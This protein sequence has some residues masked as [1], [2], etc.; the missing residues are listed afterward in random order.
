MNSKINLLRV[1]VL[2]AALGLMV[3]GLALAA[4]VDFSELP[5]T[6]DNA[7]VEHVSIGSAY[8][9]IDPRDRGDDDNVVVP[10]PATLALLGGGL[11]AL[12]V[13]RRRKAQSED[14]NE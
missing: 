3:S 8:E 13:Y 11:A 1:S 2:T 4:D 10:E 14:S 6:S 7:A 9:P 12:G 5:E